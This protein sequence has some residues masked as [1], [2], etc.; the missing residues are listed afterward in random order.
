M[1]AQ[2]K[3]LLINVSIRSCNVWAKRKTVNRHCWRIASRDWLIRFVRRC[4]PSQWIHSGLSSWWILTE[5]SRTEYCSA[6]RWTDDKQCSNR[7]NGIVQWNGCS[8]LEPLHR[9]VEQYLL[10]LLDINACVRFSHFPTTQCILFVEDM[11]LSLSLSLSYLHIIIDKTN[12]LLSLAEQSFS[13]FSRA[14]HESGSCL[15]RWWHSVAWM[16]EELAVDDGR[17][18]T[19]NCCHDE[20]FSWTFSC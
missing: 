10:R 2:V 4:Y 14:S 13:P 3:S 7:F 18:S 9:T 17:M 5:D 12:D 20:R 16:S 1:I 15:R 8:R 11:V 6:R 19:K